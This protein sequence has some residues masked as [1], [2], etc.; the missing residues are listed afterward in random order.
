MQDL[1][2]R[3]KLSDEVRTRIEDM[4]RSDRYPEGSLLPS[5]RDLMTMFGVGRPSVREAL[6]A[7]ETMGLVR[8]VNGER[9]RVTR[10]TPRSMIERLSG[11]ARLLLEQPDGIE[12]FEQ[13]R[14]FLEIGIARHAAEHATDDQIAT[15]RDALEENRRMIPKVVGFAQTDV[16]FH[17]V[18]MGIPG[19]PIF[20]SVHEALVEWLIDQRI[21]I[22]NAELENQ[23]SFEGHRLVVEAIERRDPEAAGTLMRV[24]LS[25]AQRK[26]N[27]QRNRRDV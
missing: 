20:T 3:K 22:G 24:H 8:I 19:N 5:E 14:L 12:H 11:T 7:L 6:F 4:I 9:P 23:R 26:Y 17:R 21:H 10:P 1:I 15:L 13:M 2:T 27:I 18:L 25:D 16:A